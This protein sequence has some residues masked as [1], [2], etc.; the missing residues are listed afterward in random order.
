MPRD[1]FTL[2]SPMPVPA[3]DVFAW[4]ARPAAFA[5][6]QPPWESAE[7]VDVAGPF[8]DGQRLT[9][10][11]KVGPV[12]LTWVAE[13][14]GVVPGAEFRDRQLSGPFAEWEHAHRF[15]PAGETGSFLEDHVEYRV[16]FG[17][18][19]RLFGGGVVR[20]K[21]ARMFA[22]RHAVTASDLRRHAAVPEKIAVGITGSR[23]LIGSDLARFLAAGGHPVT[24]FVRGNVKKTAVD[25]GTTSRPWN[26]ETAVD[27]R[28]FDG[29]DAVVHL[30]GDGIA[31][32]RWSA[33][34]KARIRDSRVGPTR[35]LAEAVAASYRATGRPR[36]LVSGSAIGVYGDTG[37]REVDEDSPAGTG[38]L[39]DVGREWEAATEPAQ[40]A[41]VRV[42]RLRT[43]VVLSPKG[44]ALAKQLPAF[45]A[46][47]GA[48][49]G[50]G[51]QWVS[52]IT[53]GDAVGAIHHALTRESVRGPVNLVAPGAVTNRVFG[54]VL[55]KVLRRPYLLTLPAPALRVAFGELADAALL[56][57]TRVAPRRLTESGFA[58][59]HPDL[60][61]ALKF[62]LGA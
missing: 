4:H 6:V 53:I 23:G 31:D 44:G 37:D 2:R 39:A 25:D 45:R 20:D 32:G 22:Y 42:V 5:R 57:S 40:A 9:I 35:R 43:G 56:A 61:A 41:G 30:A 1:T 55:A 33:A 29:L 3:A 59:D 51:D 50:G 15:I 8:A 49:L 54:R 7:L 62:V 52:W 18:P 26:P 27:P 28:S 19:G 47:G 21:L 46:G 14:F 24:R 11:A 17:F 10:R 34:K 16:P 48:V 60:A 58:F 13:V 38:F 12:G 36:V